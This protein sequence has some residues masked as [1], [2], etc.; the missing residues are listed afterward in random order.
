MR[1]TTDAA[2][3]AGPGRPGRIEPTDLG[4]LRAIV[5]DTDPR[6]AVHDRMPLLEPLQPLLGGLRR[7][8]V[9]AVDGDAG[10]TSLAMALLAGVSAAG[11]WCGVVGMPSWGCLAAAGYGVRLDR[12]A[13]VPEPGTAWA[14][15]V[16]ALAGGMDAV[17]VRPPAPVPGRLARRLAAKARQSGCTLLTLGRVWEGCDTR[18]STYGVEGVGRGGWEGLAAG[19]GRLRARRVTVV[20]STR[21]GIELDLWLPGEDGTVRDRGDS[22]VSGRGGVS[23]LSSRAAS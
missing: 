11:G 3:P 5:R 12:L 8:A 19:R 14:E 18:V 21:P 4:R 6:M 16:A 9:V 20:A 22:S 17:L 7:G 2:R 13:L 23:A 15:V 10:R 1:S